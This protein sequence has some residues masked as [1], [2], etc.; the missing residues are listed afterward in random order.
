MTEQAISAEVPDLSSQIRTRGH[1]HVL[2]RPTDYSESLVPYQELLPIIQ[3]A[4]VHMRGW[5]VPHIDHDPPPARREHSI[6][7]STDWEHHRELWR[8]YESG[9]FVHL[10]A[11]SEDWRDRSS[12]WPTK[13]PERERGR[14]GVTDALWSIGEYFT[15]A[16][17]LALALPRVSSLVVHIRLRGL[18][19]RELWVGDRSRAPLVGHLRT[20]ASDFDGKPVEYEVDRLVG[21]WKE[22]AL[23]TARDLFSRFDWNPHPAV[24]QDVLDGL[25]GN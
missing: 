8:F 11:L 13:D 22:F 21:D 1:W 3:S 24:L 12:L 14:L 15:L 18:K 20:D 6:E 10:S 2:I 16:S 4:S 5:D 19:G 23:E 17:R 7:G 25:W 9:Q